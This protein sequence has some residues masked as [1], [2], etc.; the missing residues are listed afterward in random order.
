[1]AKAKFEKEANRIITLRLSDTLTMVKQLNSYHKNSCCK[2]C[3]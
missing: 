2:S 1:M 3:W